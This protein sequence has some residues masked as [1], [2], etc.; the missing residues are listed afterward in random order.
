MSNPS[1][2]RPLSRREFLQL[3]GGATLAARFV[4]IPTGAAAQVA[5]SPALL[6]TLER[7]LRRGAV[8]RQGNLKAYHRLDYG[9]GEPYT[10][11]TELA[12]PPS[13]VSRRSVLHFAHMTDLQL[14]DVQSPARVEFLDRF[15]DRE[16][17][18]IPFES[19][20]RPQEAMHLQAHEQTIRTLNAIGSSPVTGA[21]IR[22]AIATGDNIDN[23]QWNELRWFIDQMDGRKTVNQ[24]S[25]DGEFEGVQNP[26]WNEREYWLPDDETTDKLKFQYGF[27]AY[28]GI[29]REAMRPIRVEGTAFP[30][31]SCNG[32]HDTL[33]QGN[34]PQNPV[35]ETVAVGGVKV[36]GPPPGVNPCDHLETFAA[37]LQQYVTD[38][39]APAR[40]VTPDPRR[41]II[42]RQEY[43]A[44]HFRTHGTPKGHGFTLQN[45]ADGTAYYVNDRVPGIRMITLDTTNPGGVS[46]GSIGSV[47]L[48]WLEARLV[49][50]HSRYFDGSGAEVATGNRDRIVILFSHHG[51]R[52]LNN[53]NQLP[54]PLNPAANDLPRH[55]AAEV[56]ALI[57]RFPNVILWVYGHSHDNR[58][59]PRRDPS[60]RTG[61]FW[62]VGTSAICDWPCQ[63]RLIEL[64][65]NGDGTLSIFCTIVD[66][67]SPAV[68]DGVEGLE[69]LAAAHRELAAN[70]P[71]K[72]ME[73]R[74]EGSP[75]D[76]NVELVIRAPFSGAGS[77]PKQ[78]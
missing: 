50:A 16:C 5:S 60:G 30:W 77:S 29:L 9:P 19:A 68:P 67:F 14:A 70:D 35:F 34:A 4:G 64:V 37:N 78:R 11:R 15:S 49:E 10:V 8:V 46:D 39:A 31:Y 27:P 26:E 21:P 66:H 69:N 63:T 13:R 61:G 22:F 17:S 32:N 65:E 59:Q 73:S 76:R 38:P 55:T 56:E 52:S 36:T 40:P 74:S 24:D 6:T 23:E 53:P 44:E 48:A 72:G 51:L 62:D 3:A 45:L 12:P 2:V 58:I 57:H 75:A 25:G 33:M 18:F 1:P 71:Q 47:Q 28:E 7:T 42:T 54:D 20:W 43:V 41:H